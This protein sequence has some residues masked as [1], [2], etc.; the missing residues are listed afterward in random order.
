M[1]RKPIL[2]VFGRIHGGYGEDV[3]SWD[4]FQAVYES[5]MTGNKG[6]LG[7]VKLVYY[8]FQRVFARLFD[9]WDRREQTHLVNAAAIGGVRDE[10]RRKPIVVII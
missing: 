6:W 3:L 9:T 4:A 5:V 7:L 10:K 8:A 1:K 2:H